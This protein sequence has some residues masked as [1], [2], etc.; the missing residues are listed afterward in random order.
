MRARTVFAAVILALLVGSA[1][2]LW[3]YSSNR[4]AGT[5]HQLARSV[6][7]AHAELARFGAVPTDPQDT[8]DLSVVVPE[9]FE[10]LRVEKRAVR[11]L[12]RAVL[13]SE[14]P[15]ASSEQLRRAVLDAL[16]N[17]GLQV[18]GDSTSENP[19]TQLFGR[20]NVQ[21]ER[22][23]GHRNLV[24]AKVETGIPCGFD[25]A[26]YLFERG[27][28]DWSPVLSV[29]APAFSRIGDAYGALDYVIS[30]ANRGEWYVL[31]A[32]TTPAC[33]SS[34]QG[35][36]YSILRKGSD[37]EHPRALLQVD[38]GLYEG[39]DEFWKL[40]ADA[41]TAQVAW[42]HQFKLDGAILIRAH[43]ARY[44]ITNDSAIRIPPV[45]FYPEDFVDEWAQLP[46]EQAKEWT[47]PEALAEA[48]PLH[49]W[50]NKADFPT[51][52]EFIQ[53]CPIPEHWQIGFVVEASATQPPPVPHLYVD[54]SK[55]GDV[56]RMDR[57]AADRAPG[58]PGSDYPPQRPQSLQ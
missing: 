1:F 55:D 12:V 38:T 36:R 51:T 45:A 25:G 48:E 34:W 49:P 30:P 37:A 28:T 27:S 11:D 19:A 32:S 53:A 41:D 2:L 14:S 16:T 10:K 54:V 33:D 5:R 58:C 13:D 31:V 23:L 6:A 22:V 44:R 39:W 21:V 20:I 17:V 29:E 7:A 42:P 35:L 8:R 56:F 15:N 43:V 9:A 57:I 3:R 24:A 47:A 4:N 18:S 26:L 46:W 52:I 40:K 50:L